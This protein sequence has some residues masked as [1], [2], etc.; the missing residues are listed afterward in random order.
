[1][2]RAFEWHSKGQGFNSP[3]LHFTLVVLVLLSILFISCPK[4]EPWVPD[5]PDTPPPHEHTFEKEWS[6][7]EIY[8]YHKATCGHDVVSDKAE[9]TFVD[10]TCSTCRYK[11]TTTEPDNPNPPTPDPDPEPDPK[12]DPEPDPPKHEHTFDTK[13][14][15][16]EIY[17]WHEATCEH[18]DFVSEKA[19]HIFENDICI[20]CDYKKPVDPDP[21]PPTP[22]PTKKG[23]QYSFNGSTYTVI[24]LGEID[25][26][27]I[28]IPRAYN[29]GKNGEASV[30]TI[31]DRAFYNT[32]ITSVILP[33]TITEIGEYAFQYTPLR[34]V[35]MGNGVETIKA[36]AFS[37]C[38]SLSN[39]EWSENLQTIGMRSF[40]YCSSLT[41]LVLPDSLLEIGAAAFS[42]AANIKSLKIGK[43][44]KTLGSSA[45]GALQNLETIVYE[46]IDLDTA[47]RLQN[48][49]KLQFIKIGENVQNMPSEFFSGCS[50]LKEVN[51][52]ATNAKYMISLFKNSNLS[53]LT[54]GQNVEAIPPYLC[55]YA[56]NLTSVNSNENTIMIGQQAF[57]NC[58]SLKSIALPNS[59]KRINAFAFRG[60]GL[61]EITIPENVIF[62]EANAFGEC[63]NLKTVYWNAKNYVQADRKNVENQDDYNEFLN[64]Y[65]GGI[66][67]KSAIESIIFGAKANIVPEGLCT[68]IVSLNNVI[69]SDS[70]KLIE[71]AAFAGCENL[72]EIT[73]PKGVKT[74]GEFAFRADE[75]LS[76]VTFEEGL[77]EIK[78][79]AFLMCR[80][81][82]EAILPNSLQKMTN[83][84]AECTY[85]TNAHLGKSLS[86]IVGDEIFT[87]STC[88]ETITIDPENSYYTVENNVLYD[89]DKIT[90]IFYPP[91]K[92]TISFEIPE[93]VTKIATNAFR[94]TLVLESVKIPNT[95]NSIG[96]YAFMGSSI[97]NIEL[98]RNITELIGTFSE[99]MFLETVSI[100][101]NINTIDLDAFDS[102]VSLQEFNVDANNN[103]YSST[104][105]SLY[106]KSGNSLIKYALGKD[107]TSFTVP[108]SI[109]RIEK[110]AFVGASNLTSITFE[111]KDK[112]YFSSSKNME[113]ATL[114][115]GLENAET[116]ATVLTDTDNYGAFYW[117]YRP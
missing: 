113:K 15:T 66:F 88:L 54:I 95:V 60:A 38:K 37:N 105:G 8:H 97:R 109:T 117:E 70:I 3:Y 115:T 28:V 46:A 99:C 64:E 111:N 63:N 62:I 75:F 103:T 114:A 39:I 110:N 12:P 27:N 42:Y 25:D 10:N 104:N 67:N 83:P 34:S 52:N 94:D 73:I 84:F 43:N 11:K 1:M 50:A 107:A 55:Q 96:N 100:G 57:E 20:I 77:I 30:T 101:S 69:L 102:C 87:G 32:N 22:E 79:Y 5:E 106:N 45:L 72:T 56:T 93:T 19:E 51:Y 14:T 35:K 89:K 61:S 4:P 31:S 21:E 86:E 49:P 9:H 47:T 82:K 68:D 6:H 74:I 36:Y 108:S 112:W 81:L 78:D 90:L 48:L 85:L 116:M 40:E 53:T 16:D 41:S 44:L 17:H 13:W 58:I 26:Y 71:Y 18:T 91:M 65:E 92:N 98:P 2:A 29:D 76:K 59:L 23:I 33:D 7:D 80:D 24:G